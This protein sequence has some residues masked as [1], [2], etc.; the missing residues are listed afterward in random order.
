MTETKITFHN[1]VE[2]K[3]QAQI[4]TGRTL[5]STC[6]AGPGETHILPAKSVRYDIFLKNGATGWEIGRKLNSEAKTFTLSRQKGRY[7]IT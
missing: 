6:L 3:V 2:I 5:V 1:R 7:V 4:Y